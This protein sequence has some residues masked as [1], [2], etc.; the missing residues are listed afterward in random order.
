[1]GMA[2]GDLIELIDF[3]PLSNRL[4]SAVFFSKLQKYLGYFFPSKSYFQLF[5]LVH[6]FVDFD[7]LIMS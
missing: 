3:C 6:H 5:F 2:Q 4:L 1:M 7:E